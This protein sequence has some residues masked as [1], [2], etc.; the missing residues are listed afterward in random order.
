MTGVFNV[1]K[2][3]IWHATAPIYDILTM[4]NMDILPW[5][6]LIKYHHQAH[7]HTT[8]VTP[9][10]GMIGHPLGIIV[11]PD[12]LTMI[13]KIGP[14]LVILNPIHITMDIG[15]A[16]IMTPIE[17]TPGH[18]TDPHDKVSHA[19]EAQAHTTTTVT[20]HTADL[21]P[22]DIFPEMTA[23]LDHTSLENSITNQHRD[24]PQAHKQHCG[25]IGTGDTNKSQ[26]TIHHPNTTVLM[27]MIVTPRMI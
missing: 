9:P 24:L 4:I 25:K 12:V 8:E 5:I 14:G 15:V 3:A 26:L 18:F 6:A 7:Q 17:A 21:Y 22:I 11:T 27:I 2:P 19:T 20:H 10:L 16:A 13:I 23:D 1:K